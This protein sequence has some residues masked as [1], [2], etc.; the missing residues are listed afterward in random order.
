MLLSIMSAFF[1]IKTNSLQCAKILFR[2]LSDSSKNEQEDEDEE[3]VRHFWHTVAGLPATYCSMYPLS[4][5]N[6]QSTVR[7]HKKHRKHR[8]EGERH[9]RKKHK[10]KKRHS[11]V[12]DED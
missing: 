11:Q 5:S 4:A 10:S 7:K 2:L 9:S 8:E 3:Q 12:G 6:P 1:P